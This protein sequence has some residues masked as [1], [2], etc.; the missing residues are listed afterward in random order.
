VTVSSSLCFHCI[1]HAVGGSPRSASSSRMS[2]PIVRIV[3]QAVLMGVNIVTK[4]FMQAYAQAKAG[5]SPCRAVPRRVPAARGRR[6]R[7]TTAS[8]A[9]DPACVLPAG[10][11]SAA[12][13]V[14][15]VGRMPLD[16]ARQ[17]LNLE[18]KAPLVREDIM[19]AFTK[20][21]EANDPDKWVA[22]RR[23]PLRGH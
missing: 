19:R 18:S 2:G 20:Y 4:A 16:Q 23:P 13:S 21:Y 15:S 10:G 8:A 6:S 22:W 17:I 3:V 14:A 1:A 5:A 9:P 12:S 7:S 11:G